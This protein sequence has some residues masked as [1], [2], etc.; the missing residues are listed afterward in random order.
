[1]KILVTGGLGYIGS[2]IVLNLLKKKHQVLVVDNL[3]NSKRSTVK[4][5]LKL[6][7]TNFKFVYSDCKNKKKIFKIFNSFKPSLV[8][9]LAGLKSV[10]DSVKNPN[11][12]FTENFLSAENIFLAMQKFKVKKL[13]FS[14]SATVYGK[15]KCL[16]IDEN[17]PTKPL[18]AY[19]ASKLAIE[20]LLKNICSM[21]ID[22]SVVSLRYF[23]PV[24]SDQSGL[25][26]DNP[27][28]PTNLFP[29]IFN[30]YKGK[31]SFLPL[32][33]NNYSTKDG[34]AIR[35][36]IHILDLVDSHIVSINFLKKKKGFKVFNVGTGKGYSVLEIIKTFERVNRT[37]INFKIKS[38]RS[39]DIPICYASVK[40]INKEIGWYSKLKINQMCVLKK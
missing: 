25:L 27:L 14:S 10:A 2:N 29:K 5:I 23:N 16:P 33:G 19:G 22:W 13:I 1:M 8:I 38:R 6:A 34:S 40:K 4:K 17:H 15:P 30:V 28:K 26:K 18:H 32:Y 9:H 20:H 39:G 11:L 21:R 7:N 36:Y 31:S 35:D 37:K 12:Y 24:G 3:A